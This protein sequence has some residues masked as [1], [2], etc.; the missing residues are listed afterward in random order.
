M[1]RTIVVDKH[2]F[3]SFFPKVFFL[4]GHPRGSCVFPL[5]QTSTKREIVRLL[6]IPLVMTKH[7]SLLPIACCFP[8]CSSYLLLL[9]LLLSLLICKRR[10]RF[11]A[12][13]VHPHTLILGY[14]P[15]PPAAS[16]LSSLSKSISPQQVDVFS[17]GPSCPSPSHFYC[18]T[19]VSI[20]SKKAKGHFPF[21]FGL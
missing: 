19:I 8:P 18:S 2:L 14:C 15:S 21:F 4:F 7:R 12:S 6:F 17:T 3:F 1:V 16:Y 20:F 10:N 9:L 11:V 5:F 13:L